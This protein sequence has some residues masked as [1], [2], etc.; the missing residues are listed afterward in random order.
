ML[1]PLQQQ[2]LL[3]QPLLLQQQLHQHLQ[4]VDHLNGLVTT[5]VMMI[6]TM[7]PVAGTEVKQ[8]QRI[9]QSSP[10]HHSIVIQNHYSLFQ[11]IVVET[12]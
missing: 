12:M 3:P 5:I 11:V 10:N 4:H 9:T 2:L 6:T 8:N 7:N 1:L